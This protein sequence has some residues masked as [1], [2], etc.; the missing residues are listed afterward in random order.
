MKIIIFTYDRFD[1]ITTSRY[2]KGMKHTVLCHTNQQKQK[3][4]NAGNIY[5]D[6][7]AT[8]QPKG[9][10]NNRNFALD[11]LNDDEPS[12]TIGRVTRRKHCLLLKK[13]H[14]QQ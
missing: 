5:G 9:L 1:T 2:F 12:S 8:N 6:I 4:I 10:S 7:I 13:E 3:F 11:M 14:M